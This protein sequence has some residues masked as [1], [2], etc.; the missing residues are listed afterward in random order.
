MTVLVGGEHLAERIQVDLISPE[1]KSI[2]I[3]QIVMF[4][5]QRTTLETTIKRSIE[6]LIG[7]QLENGKFNAFC[8]MTTDTHVV[9]S[10]DFN[11]EW[12]NVEP[13]DLDYK[14]RIHRWVFKG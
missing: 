11:G 7:R 5:L 1:E 8:D 9:T 13:E 2:I 6:R 10:T 12:E 14:G 3:D 4:N